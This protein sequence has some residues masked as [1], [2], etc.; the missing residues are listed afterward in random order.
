MSDRHQHGQAPESPAV[1]GPLPSVRDLLAACAAAR[2]V[3][4]PPRAPAQPATT[5]EGEAGPVT[6]P[7]RADRRHAA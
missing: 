7:D 6:G 3:S 1:A 5:A 2:T 4:T